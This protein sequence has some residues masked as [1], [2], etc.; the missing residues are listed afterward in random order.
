MLADIVAAN[1]T[2]ALTFGDAEAAAGTLRATA[3]NQHILDARLFAKDG[4]LLATYTPPGPLGAP[5]PAARTS[6]RSASRRSPVFE[7]DHLRV[8]RPIALD[9]EIIGH[10]SV[11]S[12]TADV[13]TRLG[14][15]A[16]IVAG[17][18]FGTFWIAFVLSHATARLIFDPIAR[19]IQRDPARSRRRPLR[20]SRR[21]GRR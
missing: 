9:G 14:R 5:C 16:T 1:S 18:L 20:R 2:A 13:W 7:G 15:F 19:L 6:P 10:I 12:D 11:D 8:V 4:T 17:T 3:L 21:R